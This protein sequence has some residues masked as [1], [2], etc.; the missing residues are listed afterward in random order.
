MVHLVDVT[1]GPQAG[2]VFAQIQPQELIGRVIR[3]IMGILGAIVLIMFLYG[4][5]MWMTARGNADRISTA[6]KTLIWA[7]LGT[8][9]IF[10]SYALTKFVLN[11][12]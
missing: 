10:A 3:T 6:L 12:F 5:I 7:A 1:D 4:G 2:V 9:T 8:V 11:I